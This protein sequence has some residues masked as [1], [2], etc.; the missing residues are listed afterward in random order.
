MSLSSTIESMEIDL[1]QGKKAIIDYE[2]YSNISQS[3]WCFDASNGYPVSRIKGTRVRLHRFL[4][5]PREGELIDHINRDKLDN[6]RSNLRI[7]DAKTNVRNRGTN[8]NNTSGFRGVIKFRGKWRAQI[9]PNYKFIDLG[10]Y[11][12]AK[13]AALAYNAA[14]STLLGKDAFLNKI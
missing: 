7:V 11:E 6:R 9:T 14:A 1:T 3:S 12:T 5:K 4:L 8:K 13:K 10:L 2:D